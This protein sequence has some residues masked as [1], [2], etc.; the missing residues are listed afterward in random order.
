MGGVKQPEHLPFVPGVSHVFLLDEAVMAV[1]ER[2]GSFKGIFNCLLPP[3][4]ASGGNIS[5]G[6]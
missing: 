4:R 1:R 5:A 6:V 3:L 2:S